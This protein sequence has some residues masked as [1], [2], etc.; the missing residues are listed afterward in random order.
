MRTW[1]GCIT[2]PAHTFSNCR[3]SA[4]RCNCSR[5]LIYR[6]YSLTSV[7][8]GRLRRANICL[9]RTTIQGIVSPNHR[10]QQ[11]PRAVFSVFFVYPLRYGAL[12][13]AVLSYYPPVCT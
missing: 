8:M 5:E 1:S 9:C 2:L 6:H 12:E 11:I 4:H 10:L 13:D 7:V 3:G